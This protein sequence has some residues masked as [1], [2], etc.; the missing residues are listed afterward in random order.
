M[1]EEFHFDTTPWKDEP[2][3]VVPLPKPKKGEKPKTWSMDDPNRPKNPWEP[4]GDEYSI[5]LNKKIKEKPEWMKKRDE[6]PETVMDI[7]K[8]IEKR[9]GKDFMD[10]K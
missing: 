10:I 5:Y 7:I 4:G 3:S 2:L 8:R 6:K 9:E 1:A